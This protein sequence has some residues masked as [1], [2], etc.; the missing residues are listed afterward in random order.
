VSEPSEVPRT[1]AAHVVQVPVDLVEF[2]A[3]LLALERRVR[4]QEARDRLMLDVAGGLRRLTEALGPLLEVVG[5]LVESRGAPPHAPPAPA[6]RR[7]LAPPRPAPSAAVRPPTHGR[8]VE[9]ERLAAA[10]ARL[11]EAA[12]E[13][14][15]SS[16]TADAAIEAVQSPSTA[17]AAIPLPP[18]SAPRAAQRSWLLGALRR[19][20]ARDPDE[21][22]RLLV[23]LLPASHLAEIGP[24]PRLP[25][26]PATVARVVVKGRLRRRLGWEMAQLAC[27]LSVVSAL[28]TLVRL[29]VSPTRLHAAGV[30]LDA[31]VALALVA[32][33][34][35]PRWTLG[36]RFTL[37]HVDADATYLE[38]RDGRRPALRGEAPAG[39][40]QTTVRCRGRDLFPLLAGE[41]G[42]VGTVEG[43]RRPLE[44]VQGWFQDATSA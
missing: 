9:P 43:E 12:T 8:A 18:A 11:R 20:V 44:L 4:E 1:A 16:S 36:H 41:P 10:Q 17:D 21:A 30:R 3:R 28:A 32:N 6:S 22:G 42:A 34:I 40:V 37:A 33:A 27:E 25:G 39:F 24:I 19:M 29:R 23:A 2:E 13:A 35:D 5:P 7:P 26:P 14:V 38:V 31:R 15:Q